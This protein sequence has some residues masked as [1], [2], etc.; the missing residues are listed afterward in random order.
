MQS[1]TWREEK[2]NANEIRGTILYWCWLT[3][4]LVHWHEKYLTGLNSITKRKTVL[5]RF[6][7]LWEKVEESLLL[8]I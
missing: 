8:V 7:F 6:S 3:F 1:M 4:F 5:A 2:E